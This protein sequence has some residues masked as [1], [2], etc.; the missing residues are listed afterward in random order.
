MSPD[1]E[2]ED[3]G[4]GDYC[5][6]PVSVGDGEVLIF[7]SLEFEV[8]FNCYAATVDEGV[9]FVL[10]KETRKWVPAEGRGQEPGKPSGRLTRV[11]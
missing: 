10:C 8:D 3:A 5:S 2:L 6:T 11:K 1:D 7:D 9:L 4:P